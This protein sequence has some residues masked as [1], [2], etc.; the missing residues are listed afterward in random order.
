MLRVSFRQARV[1]GGFSRCSFYSVIVR[2]CSADRRGAR[3]VNEINTNEIWHC[4]IFSPAV[5]F[6]WLSGEMTGDIEIRRTDNEI[7]SKPRSM[8]LAQLCLLG[9]YTASQNIGQNRS[10]MFG[11]VIYN[12]LSGVSSSWRRWLIDWLSKA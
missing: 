5:K 3:A 9:R 11:A 1:S 6:D 7:W 4:D 8:N 10:K 12:R 2:S